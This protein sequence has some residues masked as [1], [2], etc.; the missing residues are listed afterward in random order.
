[1]SSDRFSQPVS[2]GLFFRLLA[3]VLGAVL[4]LGVI[5][6]MQEPL[7]H[8]R[9]NVEVNVLSLDRRNAVS[10]VVWPSEGSAAILIPSRGITRSWHD[11]VVPIASLTKMMTAYV[12]LHKLPLVSGSSGP[13]VTISNSDVEQYDLMKESDQSSVLVSSGES[14]CE[15]DLLSG[16]LVHSASNY[17]VLLADMVAGN[18]TQFVALM[19]ETAA[20]LGL[21][22]THYADVS[23]FSNDSVSNA[24]DQGRL[25]VLLMKSPLVRGIVDQSRVTLPVAGT[26]GSFT[27][28][29]GSDNVIGVKSGRTAQA[30][31]CD[32]MAMTFMDGSRSA[33]AFAVVLGQQGGDQLG[34]AGDA[35][36]ALATSATTQVSVTLK[37]G[38]VV[39]SIH[40][41]RHGS[42]VVL[43]ESAH[44]S[45]WAAKGSWRAK[46]HIGTITR[47]LHAGQV[48]GYVSFDTTSRRRISLVVTRSVAPPSLWQRLT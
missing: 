2:R 12:V 20:S 3:L 19:N 35:A 46:V 32:V 26:V 21:R 10:P 17:A 27:P 24:L 23:G 11:H 8:E 5:V 48:V 37:K 45:W 40:W 39:G 42:A 15:F 16:M 1:M 38:T 36:L 29:V 28:Y 31:G 43:G 25:A 4:A 14:L 47:A 7:L 18:V 41:A 33:T 6:V 44:F 22:D 13:C 9:A 30:G 34:P